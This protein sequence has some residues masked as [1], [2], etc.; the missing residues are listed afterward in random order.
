MLMVKFASGLEQYNDL[1]QAVE[2]ADAFGNAVSG[3]IG[4]T[5]A[6]ILAQY[7]GAG[8][9]GAAGGLAG[10]FTG[11][12][13]QSVLSTDFAEA[14]GVAGA[15]VVLTHGLAQAIDGAK[16][17]VVGGLSTKALMWGGWAATRNR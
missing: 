10:G 15:Q 4:P 5:G 9:G 7:G 13:L 12:T 2:V 1:S 17:G 3:Q 16:W 14:S 6:R 8:V 11:G